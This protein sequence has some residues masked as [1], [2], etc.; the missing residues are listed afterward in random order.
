MSDAGRGDHGVGDAAA[1][2]LLLGE[3]IRAFS[4]YLHEV[5][6]AF[7]RPLQFKIVLESQLDLEITH[8]FLLS[9]MY[10][11]NIGFRRDRKA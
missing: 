1:E 7:V 4:E 3:H 6:V 5:G 2:G 9:Q 11:Y 8:T 10:T